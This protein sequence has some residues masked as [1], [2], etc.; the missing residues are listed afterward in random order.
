M[1]KTVA[2]I[3]AVLLLGAAMIACVPDTPDEASAAEGT[4]ATQTAE[5]VVDSAADQA[6]K[7]EI[8]FWHTYTDHHEEALKK[9]VSA[10]NASQDSYE[11][12][13]EQQPYSEYAA[14]LMQAVGN[15]TG[16]DMVSMY[17][18]DA[19]NYINDGY[20]YDMSGFINDPETGMPAFYTDVPAGVMADIT[21]WG[22]NGIYMIPEILTGEV[23]FYNKTMFDELGLSEPET[24]TDVENCAKAIYQAYGIPGFGTDSITDTYQCLIS[25]AGSGYIDTASK[26]MDIDREIGIEKLNWFADGVKDGYFRLVGEDMYFS[27][28]FG[29]QAIGMYVGAS[30]GVDYVYMAIP[31]G[32]GHFEVGCCPIPQEGTVKYISNWANGY[33][34]LSVDE[35]HARGVYTFMKYFTSTDVCVEWCK[36]LGAVPAYLSALEDPAF[37]E[38]AASNIAVK[39][40][41]EQTAF[42][43]HLAS[44]AGSAA[45]R[46]EIDKM[47]QTVALGVSDADTAFDAFITNCNAALQE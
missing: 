23:L 37:Q 44:I 3:M 19:I 5:T 32:E 31:E 40:L 9:I 34:C 41:S 17:P 11:V 24:W 21:Q 28:P 12:V 25:Q 27:N 14:K 18:S 38:Y 46:T 22:D 8:V 20:I 7:L 42:I 36:A 16:P 43:G 4:D 35:Q 10:F 33:V 39:A 15:G 47:V 29:S 1:K 2:V 45:V 6:E 30:A 13:M 26:S